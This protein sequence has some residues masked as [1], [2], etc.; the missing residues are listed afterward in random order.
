MKFEWD[1]A[2]ELSNREK[3]GVGF[4]EAS[5]VFGD[6][7][8]LSWLDQVHSEAEFRT[9]TVGYTARQRLVI[10]AH[11]DRGDRIRIIAAR[12]ATRAEEELYAS[13]EGR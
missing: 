13:G 7:F 4:E 1:L 12:P 5:T 6:R 10:V 2:K 8:A 9:L 11:T 3:H